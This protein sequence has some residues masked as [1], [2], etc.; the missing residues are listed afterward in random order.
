MSLKRGKIGPRLLLMTNRKL[1]ACFRLVPTSTN[2]DDLEW[3]LHYQ[4]KRCS[5]V[6]LVPGSIRFT[7]IFLALHGEGTSN[8]N[9]V[10]INGISQY[11]H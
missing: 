10:V 4:Q 8:N 7:V 5:P 6:T 3:P 11:F 1:H 9:G 2:L